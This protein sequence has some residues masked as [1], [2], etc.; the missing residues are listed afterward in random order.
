MS[1]TERVKKAWN[2]FNSDQTNDL[3][4]VPKLQYGMG[5]PIPAFRSNRLYSQSSFASAVF[6]RIAMDVSTVSIEHVKMDEGNNKRSVV[7]SGLHRCLNQEANID[8]NSIQFMQDLVYSMF[9]EGVVAVV[10]VDTTINPTVSAGY[11]ILSMRVGKITEWFPTHVKV[12][13]YN[14]QTGREQEIKVPKASTAIIENPMYAVA[15]GPNVTLKRLLKKMAQLDDVDELLS[16]G[17]LDVLIQLP[18]AVKTELQENNAKERVKL[19]ERQLEDNKYGVGYIDATEKIHQLNRPL[20]DKLLDDI[21]WLSEQFYN[22]L[23]M[24]ENVFNGTASEQ[25]MRGYYS[26]IIDPLLDNII[27]EFERKFITQTARTQGHALRSYRDPFALMPIS[28]LAEV[29][30]TFRRNGILSSNEIRGVMGYR[31]SDDPL[32]SQLFNPNIKDDERRG[33]S[34]NQQENESRPSPINSVAPPTE[35]Q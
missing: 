24:T 31:P 6:N 30:D 3:D 35:E 10:P 19:L 34:G 27:K 33:K 28:A 13:L 2:A 20:N 29:A 12:N 14:E 23:G 15:N 26:R 1:F 11:D 9:D 18:N 21:K 25:E 4:S 16:S 7:K 32:A 8:Q 17:K 22:Q 5:N